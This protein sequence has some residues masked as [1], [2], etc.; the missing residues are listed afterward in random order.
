MELLNLPLSELRIK[1]RNGKAYVFDRLRNRF[2]RLTPEEQVRQQWIAFLIEHKGYPSGRM[3]N[4]VE[5][6][7]GNIRKRCDTVLYDNYLQPLMILE[8]KSPATVI[9]QKAF[10][11]IAR[12]NLTLQVP[13]L[14][15]SN[16]I[17][18]FCCR[19]AE[20]GKAFVF[21]NEIPEYKKMTNE[22]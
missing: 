4:E 20:D 12:Y 22:E 8:Y 2:V 17:D 9:S 11:Q 19:T 16:G 1:Q 13:W 21:V 15:V 18:H 7:V 6:A 14:I 3:A 5:I 10:D